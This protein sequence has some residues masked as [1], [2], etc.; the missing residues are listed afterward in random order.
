ME[1]ECKIVGDLLPLYLENML[2]EET[3]EFVKQH[4]KSCKQCSDEFEQMKVGVKNHTIEENEGKKDVQAL[5]TVKKKLRKKTMKTISITGACLIAVAILLHT[6]PIYRLA[7]LSAYSDFYTNAQ[8]MKALSIGSS[9]DRKEA[10]DVLQ[11][12][13]KA[14]QDVHHTRAQNEKDYGLLSRYAT[15]IDDYPEENLDFSEYSLQLWSAHF[16]GDKGSLW[17][18]YSSETLNQKGDVV[19]GSWEVPSFWEVKKNENGKWVVTNI[20][21]HP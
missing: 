19:C 10:Q 1:N 5:M 2:S 3:M 20:Y 17:V 13:H 16:D 12:A 8:V 7:M 18:Y 14:F 9:S 4:L 21:E 6:F 11:M 15:S